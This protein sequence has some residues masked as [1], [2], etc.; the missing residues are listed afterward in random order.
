MS[1]RLFMGSMNIKKS[2]GRYLIKKFRN[3]KNISQ[4]KEK[5]NNDYKHEI[6]SFFVVK[7]ETKEIKKSFHETRKNFCR[8]TN[9][10][11]SLAYKHQIRE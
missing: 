4:Q 9:A 3:F 11:S 6:T 10:S 8:Q 5:K 2:L 7:K 1:V